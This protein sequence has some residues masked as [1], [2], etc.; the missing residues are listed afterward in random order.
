MKGF[1]QV[2]TGDGKGK[3]TAALGLALRAAGAGKKVFIAQFLKGR[4]CSEQRSIARLAPDITLKQ[5][6][7][8]KFILSKPNPGDIARARQGLED[9]K[10]ALSSGTYDLLILDEINLAVRLN[11]LSLKEILSLMD[12]KPDHV[13]LVLTGRDAHPRILAR[14]DLVTEMKEIKHYYSRGVSARKGIEK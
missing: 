9:V 1:V 2:Y 5:Y 13:E 12:A 7:G 11:L 3:T 14:A 4:A 8:R 10:K 6:G